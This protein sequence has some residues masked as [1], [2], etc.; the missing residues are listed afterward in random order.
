MTR[1]TLLGWL[2]WLPLA[3]GL[4]GLWLASAL[5]VRAEPLPWHRAEAV[6]SVLSLVLPHLWLALLVVCVPLYFSPWR[7]FRVLLV[8]AAASMA[9]MWGR[10]WAGWPQRGAEGA[11][12]IRVATWNVARLGEFCGRA[13]CPTEEAEAM[14]CV[15]EAL[16]A[17][18]PD[19][20]A[21]QE[22]SLRR[23]KALEQALS[24]EC[25]L[26]SGQPAWTDYEGQGIEKHGGL[27]VCIPRGGDWRLRSVKHPGLP[28]SWHYVFTEAQHADGTLINFLSVHF[29][30]VSLQQPGDLL[31]DVRGTVRAVAR[32]NM[33]Q[34]KQASQLLETTERFNDPTILAGDFNS[35]RDTRT[36]HGLR[37]AFVDTF[38]QAG[39]GYG[40]SRTFVL[41]LRIDFI[42]ASQPHFAVRSARHT[43]SGCSDHRLVLSTVQLR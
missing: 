32:A 5:S 1:T 30:P 18:R 13:T 43:A 27:A 39:W 29:K 38:A 26:S 11:P 6:L 12:E 19:L 10:S 2:V 35:T 37:K 40:T 28:P 41:P 22:V 4:A 9:W 34:Q 21:L 15:G 20:L 14:R 8:L 42:Y 23:L 25:R 7:Q 3:L 17:H 24:W 16:E 31:A 36:H 33:A